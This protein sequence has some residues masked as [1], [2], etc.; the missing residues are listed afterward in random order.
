M[1]NRSLRVRSVFAI[2]VMA[3]A[4]LFLAACDNPFDPLHQSSRIDGLSY[5]DWSGSWDRWD[6]DPEYD[7]YVITMEYFNK[8]G[9]NLEFRDKSHDIKIE[10][11]SQTA[12]TDGDITVGSLIFSQT[13]RFSNTNNDIYIAKELYAAA[14]SAAGY[15]LETEPA[16]VFVLIHV[17]PPDAY[18]QAELKA[19]YSSQIVYQPDTGDEPNP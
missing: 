15:D 11:Y 4:L 12:S 19:G 6:S 7:G 18:P 9:D 2:A 13:V 14:L 16:E 17:Y 3:F 1:N 8:Y 10:F 5:I